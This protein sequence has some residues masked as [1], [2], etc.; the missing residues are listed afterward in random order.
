MFFSQGLFA[1]RLLFSV[2]GVVC[3]LDQTRRQAN[4]NQVLNVQK[5]PNEYHEFLFQTLRHSPF[6]VSRLRSTA[7]DGAE[8]ERLCACLAKK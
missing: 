7:K 8:R 5:K 1:F 6:L 3:Y 4:I 2:F